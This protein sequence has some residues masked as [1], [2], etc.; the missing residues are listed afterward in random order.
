MRLLQ[1]P[2]AFETSGLSLLG[3]FP[4]LLRYSGS[5][6]VTIVIV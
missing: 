1:S 4:L 2:G 3:L 6:A 5:A